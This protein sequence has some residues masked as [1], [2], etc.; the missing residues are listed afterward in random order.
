YILAGKGTA[1]DTDL[2]I[3]SEYEGKPVTEIKQKAFYDDDLITSVTIPDSIKTIGASAFWSCGE[4]KTVNV[5]CGITKI[6]S[7]AFQFC[8]KLV[9]VNYAGDTADWC[10]ITFGNQY[11]NPLYYGRNLYMENKLLTEIIIP[12]TVKTVNQAAFY[13]CSATALTLHNKVTTIGNLAFGGCTGLTEIAIPDSV[14]SLGDTAFRDCSSL[15]TVSLGNGITKLGI[16]VF[17]NCDKIEYTE[18][19]NALYLGNASNRRLMLVSAKDKDISSCTIDENCKFIANDAFRNCTALSEIAIPKNVAIVGEGAFRDCT[20]LK[21]VTW[22]ATKATSI[23]TTF[24]AAPFK[25]CSEIDEIVVGENVTAIPKLV[26]KDSGVKSLTINGSSTTI[27]GN[28]MQ[29]CVNLTCITFK[30]T[31]AQWK[32]LAKGANWNNGT[33]DYSV[34]CTDGKLDKDGNVIE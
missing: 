34:Q 30:G 25:G 22:N 12:S 23:T 14:T 9:K 24:A 6:N 4:L 16:N 31:T 13:G 7:N 5:G 3:P 28:A 10:G 20:A 21:M 29:N 17:L 8:E 18:H 27:A 33:G 11:A 32:A 26:F 1:T 2:V 15:K 19:E